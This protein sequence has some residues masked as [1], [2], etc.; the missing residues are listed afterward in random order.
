MPFMGTVSQDCFDTGTRA[1]S[2]GGTTFLLDFIVPKPGESLLK[3]YEQWRAWADPKVHHDF[4]LHCCI[5]WWSDQVAKEMAELVKLGVVSFKFFLAYK[6]SL[7]VTDD[8]MI[9]CL[10]RCKELGA[11][12]MVHAENGYLVDHLQKKI[13]SAGVTGP[14]GHYLSRSKEVEAEATHRAIVFAN[15]IG[16][17]LYVVHLMGTEAAEEVI[18]ARQK[19]FQVFGETLASTL[20]IDGS[21][22]L[23]K[24]WDVAAGAVMSPAL[25]MD[26][27]CK[28]RMMKYLAMGAVHTVG[29]DNCTFSES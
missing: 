6:G 5:T 26:P 11:L 19:G 4:G 18:R 27:E 8:E 9:K 14:E 29:T 7:M 21:K 1:T 16:T 22:Y 3:A 24:N 28:V 10:E 23:D 25:S 20:G 15:E 17:P 12:S 13:L 2:A